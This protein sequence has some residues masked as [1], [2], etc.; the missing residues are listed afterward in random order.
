MLGEEYESSADL[1]RLDKCNCESEE[2]KVLAQYPTGS[3]IFCYVNPDNPREVVVGRGE[4]WIWLIVLFLSLFPLVFWGVTILILMYAFSGAD[5]SRNKIDLTKK[6]IKVGEEYTTVEDEVTYKPTS[7][8]LI[9]PIFIG[10]FTTI[11]SI[12]VGMGVTR[13]IDDWIAGFPSVFMTVVVTAFLLLTLY[14]IGKTLFEFTALFTPKPLITLK[15]GY[16]VQ[17]KPS[18]VSWNIN[19]SKHPVKNLTIKL[20]GVEHAEYER[21]TDIE[22]EEALFYE[23]VLLEKSKLRFSEK[24]STEVTIPIENV[25]PSMRLQNNEIRWSII[26]TGVMTSHPNIDDNYDVVVLPP[27]LNPKKS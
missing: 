6:E 21:G 13:A 26:V 24:G 2:E 8:R 7:D 1:S 12:S 15:P 25:M 23:Q 4:K 19:I 20:I 17:G 9:A 27:E 18:K 11:L 14:L 22:E 10:I 16:F 3:K 5:M